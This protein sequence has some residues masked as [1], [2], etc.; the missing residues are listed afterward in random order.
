MVIAGST[1][2]E[3]LDDADETVPVEEISVREVAGGGQRGA[4]LGLSPP[5]LL[6]ELPEAIHRQERE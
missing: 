1:E 3:L 2:E 4:S 5:Q 6:R